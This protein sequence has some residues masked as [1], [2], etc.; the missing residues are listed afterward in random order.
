M[1]FSCDLV[2]SFYL[3]SHKFIRI[4][5]IQEFNVFTINQHAICTIHVF[6]AKAI[7]PTLNGFG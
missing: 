1:T 3:N 4:F 7:K 5:E 2:G 6:A